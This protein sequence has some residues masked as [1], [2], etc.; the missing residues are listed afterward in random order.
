MHQLVPVDKPVVEIDLVMVVVVVTVA[1]KT[2]QQAEVDGQVMD[3]TGV[4]E[5]KDCP[6]KMVVL[7]ELTH[8]ATVMEVLEVAVEPVVV[9]VAEVVEEVT[10][11]VEVDITQVVVEMEEVEVLT[12]VGQISITDVVV[13]GITTM[14]K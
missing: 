6:T 7:E 5:K 12:I 11:V 9:V 1:L 10:L 13:Q 4:G 2:M 14:E 3:K 8:A